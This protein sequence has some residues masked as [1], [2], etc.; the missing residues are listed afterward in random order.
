M[1]VINHLNLTLDTKVKLKQVIENKGVSVGNVPFSQYPDLIMDLT[2][3]ARFRIGKIAYNKLNQNLSGW[4]PCDGSKLLASTYPKI[5]EMLDK[6][7]RQDEDLVLIVG[8]PTLASAIDYCEFTSDGQHLV[9]GLTSEECYHTI[10]TSDWTVVD[11]PVMV[12]GG[13]GKRQVEDEVIPYLDLLSRTGQE[14][15]NDLALSSDKRY[16][17]V[18]R[19]K[20]PFLT[21]YSVREERAL[22]YA[23][24][25]TIPPVTYGAFT[26]QPM[27]KVKD[28]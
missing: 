8:T 7:S 11:T 9:V 23:T 4:R 22:G 18:G 12:E 24:L 28:V 13:H 14:N 20:P 27:I 10:Q 2:G 5:T 17:A 3:G 16:L 26:L 21:V 1:S 19:D 6:V 25:P 15:I